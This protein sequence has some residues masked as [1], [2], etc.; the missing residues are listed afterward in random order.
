MFEKAK[1]T[2]ELIC[3][4]RV[5]YAEV[6]SQRVVFNSRYLEYADLVITE[7]WRTI[8]LPIAGEAALEFHVVRALVDYARP[9]RADEE[10]D[11]FAHVA[12]I[13]NSSMTTIIELHGADGPDLRARIELVHVHVDLGTGRPQRIPDSVRQLFGFDCTPQPA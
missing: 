13:G 9:L 3:R 10:V 2:G 1:K 12:A 4:F 5:R 8:G 11:A 6:D 7:F